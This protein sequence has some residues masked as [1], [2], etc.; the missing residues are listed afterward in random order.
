MTKS[1]LIVDDE[2]DAL[3]MS[4]TILEHEGYRV[5]RAA[6][7]P[8]A[9]EILGQETPSLILLDLMMPG[10]DGFQFCRALATS[11]LARGVP[12]LVLTAL[13]IFTYSEETLGDLFGVRRFM[14]KPFRPA[15]LVEQVERTVGS[16][17][18]STN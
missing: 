14:Y 5:L 18:A 3:E 13:E 8:Q 9:L 2:E 12:I 16:M 15:T 6:S 17:A 4:S 10:M 11:G 7:G 1:I